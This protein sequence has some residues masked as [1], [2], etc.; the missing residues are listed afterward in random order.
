MNQLWGSPVLAAIIGIAG[1]ILI[2]VI[3]MTARLHTKLNSLADSVASIAEDVREIR[4]DNNIMRW[5]DVR[6]TKPWRK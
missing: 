5:S 3:T 4:T 6:G 2:S 1:T